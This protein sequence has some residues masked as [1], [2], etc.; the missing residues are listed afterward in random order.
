M[1]V[2]GCIRPAVRIVTENNWNGVKQ[3]FTNSAG[4]L[5]KDALSS[6]REY[7]NC[8]QASDSY[9]YNYKFFTTRRCHKKSQSQCGRG[10]HQTRSRVIGE[11]RQLRSQSSTEVSTRA[12]TCEPSATIVAGR[13]ACRLAETAVRPPH[14]KVLCGMLPAIRRTPAKRRHIPRAAAPR[15]ATRRPA[16]QA[17]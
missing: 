4:A 16:R 2:L 7:K 12:C 5:Q 17:A 3:N 9:R 10:H 15:P 6:A 1:S 14:P 13:R 8:N 11:W